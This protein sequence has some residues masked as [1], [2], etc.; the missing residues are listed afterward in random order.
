MMQPGWV[1]SRS[2][3]S[4]HQRASV[5]GNGWYSFAS[6]ASDHFVIGVPFWIHL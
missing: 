2:K 1:T 4:E 6:L 3:A 5:L